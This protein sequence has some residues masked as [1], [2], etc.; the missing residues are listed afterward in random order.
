MFLWYKSQF[1]EIKFATESTDRELLG[2]PV[3]RYS[4][5]FVFLWYKSQFCE[6]KFATERTD[7]ELLGRPVARYSTVFVFLWTARSGAPESPA[8]GNALFHTFG[9]PCTGPGLH[10]NF[11]WKFHYA[12]ELRFNP[13]PFINL[14]PVNGTTCLLHIYTVP[15]NSCIR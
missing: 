3:A 2:R 11:L 4:A 5:A 10:L 15:W 12:A 6:I 1:C 7:R 14:P 8:M 13:Q 9:S